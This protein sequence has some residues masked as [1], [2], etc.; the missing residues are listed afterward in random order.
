MTV[1]SLATDTYQN[2][3][4][5]NSIIRL[6]IQGVVVG[7]SIGYWIKNLVQTLDGTETV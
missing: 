3:L 4:A 7:T 6:L 2:I 1:V 5:T